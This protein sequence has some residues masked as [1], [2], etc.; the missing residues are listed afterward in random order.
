MQSK[1]QTIL[2]NYGG[3]AVFT[4]LAVLL[5]WLLDPWL[6]E[7]LPLVTL[8]G[9]VAIAVWLCGYR[10]AL[11]A[12]VLGYLAC[13]WLFIEP[14]GA[15]GIYSARDLIGLVAYLVSCGIIV[16]FGEALLTSRR[17]VE[18]RQRELE[19]ANR[20]LREIEQRQQR[21]T[22]L[23]PFGAWSTDLSGD[24][25]YLSPLFLD[26]VGQTL[27]EHRRAWT[28]TIHPEDAA[29]TAEKW[30]EFVGANGIWDHEFRIRGKDSKYRT[31]LARGFPVRD[32]DDRVTGY[33]GINYDISDRKQ[34]EDTLRQSEGLLQGILGSITDA[35][36]VLDKNW[37]FTFV[38]DETSRRMGMSREALL[39][40]NVWELYPN[41]L[42]TESR[43]VLHQAM[44]DR[45]VVEY[46]GLFPPFG[47][48]FAYKVYPTQDG[49]L[50]VLSRDITDRRRAEEALRQTMDDLRV[51]TES[52]AAPV[53]RCSRDLKY[54]WVSNACAE[55][56]G[57]PA[58]EIIGQPIVSIIGPEAFEK[59]N[60]HFQE[61]LSGRVVRYEEEVHYK[62]IGPRWISAVYT[63]TL[64]S[65]GV[66]D[67][68]VAVLN[69][70]TERK[71][72]EE[73]LRTSEDRLANE[74]EAISRLHALSTRLL[75]AVDVR[76]A[77]DDL[78]ENAI[79]TSEAQFGNIQLYNPQIGAL[80]I[81]AQRGFQQD[82]LDYFR[83]VRVEDGSACAQAMQTGERII[84]EDVQVEPT[85]EP[86]RRIAEAADFRSVISTPLKNRSSGVIG[87]LS[88]H[89]RQPHHPSERD[90]R[91]LDLYARHAV[92][93][94]E[95]SRFE[96]ALKEAD[97]RKD[98]FL[99]TLA[100][101]LR[102]PLAPIRNAL[103]IMTLSSDAQAHAEARTIMERQLGQMVHLIDDL[104]DVSRITLG[105]VRLHKERVEFAE[106]VRDAVDA[107]RPLMESLGHDLRV[108]LPVE[109]V[110]LNADS[111]RL[112]QV[113]SNLLN[114]AAKYSDRSAHIDLTAERGGSQIVVSVKDTGIGLPPEMLNQVFDLFT[115][116]VQRDERTR[117]G[118]GIGL[119]LAKSLVEL[120]G[121]S[122]EAQSD[123]LG[124]G[125]VF[126]V[127]LP[128]SV[129][130]VVSESPP[131]EESPKWTNPLKARILVVDDL[132]DSAESLARLLRIGGNEVRTAHDGLEA[133]AEAADF[134]PDLVLMDIG[135]PRMD[136]YEA[137]RRIR[138][139]AFGSEVILV[140]V[141]GW[142]QAEDRRKSKAAGFDHHMVKPVEPVAIERLLQGLTVRG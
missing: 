16:S 72:M 1:T 8:F 63:P 46:E 86:H 135:M 19:E 128:I 47:G 115:R 119:T 76:R 114:N 12:V 24:A 111:I 52:M 20:H 29:S 82:F 77:L 21:I 3:A 17:R 100:H 88:V 121:G 108:R 31:I 41:A 73:A 18:T 54:L 65:D 30:R 136:G 70:L 56:I 106:V 74:L 81:L 49:G 4:A 59:L 79:L 55:W 141:T 95:R 94:I 26:M 87:M 112:T 118:L 107:C 142:G 78:L 104:L 97:R 9:A 80:E 44:S 57:R 45:N 62:G 90:Q 130:E 32:G 38:N 131:G 6:G 7:H 11:L 75:S 10:P 101:E 37:C 132:Q 84:I 64:D 140:A 129:A 102:N 126:I 36:F 85:F 13:N 113:L 139:L 92:D 103:E 66:P 133:V 27:E 40:R 99:A 53:T 22:D 120:H 69:D 58:N 83:T 43:S 51:V 28:S 5:R 122:I 96:K 117:G 14:R 124:R 33:V 123:G 2:L 98:E 89:F 116:V 71:R 48:W 110:H 60:A 25:T 23:I 39:G 50:A 42:G 61:V 67:G 138:D 137:C 68:W 125:S 127:R 91:L 134:R 34:V 93:F 35:F 109:P 105:Q 15:F